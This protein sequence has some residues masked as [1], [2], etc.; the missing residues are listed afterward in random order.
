MR[1]A[2][3]HLAGIPLV[4][5]QADLTPLQIEFLEVA[6]PR[7]QAKARDQAEQQGGAAGGVLRARIDERVKGR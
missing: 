2:A 7:V 5:T 6:I 4:A 1:I 3:F